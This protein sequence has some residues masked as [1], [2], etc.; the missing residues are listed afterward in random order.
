MNKL[1]SAALA[2]GMLLAVSGAQAAEVLGDEK[3]DTV[4][5]GVTTITLTASSTFAAAQGIGGTANAIGISPFTATASVVSGSALA[6]H[7]GA[8][9][10]TV[11]LP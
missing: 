8:T 3:L 7:C 5:A 2:I 1:L 9:P 10:C 6:F 4:T 11:V